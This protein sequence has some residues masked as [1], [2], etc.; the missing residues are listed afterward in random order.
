[1]KEEISGRMDTITRTKLDRNLVKAINRKVILVA[2]YRMN[3][4]KFTISELM[5]LDHVIKRDLRKSN[6]LVQKA[7]DE[8]LHLKRKGER[9][10]LKSLTEV[11]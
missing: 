5:N 11:Y 1:M 9:G 4:Y 6:V 3:V 10:G 8:R 7:S 2:V